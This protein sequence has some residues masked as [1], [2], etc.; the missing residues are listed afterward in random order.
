MIKKTSRAWGRPIATLLSLLLLLGVTAFAADEVARARALAFQGPEHRQEA[1]QLLEERLKAM[2]DDGDAL[3]LYGTILSW[4]G[5]YN[6]G[7]AA[8]QKVLDRNPDHSDALPAM[9]NLELW[10]DHP[11][12]AEE[13]ARGALQRHP[14]NVQMLLFLARAQRNENHAHDA[15]ATLDTLLQVE[16]SNEEALQMRRRMIY[17]AKQ[18]EASYSFNSDFFS[19][20]FGAQQEQVLE[21]RGPTKIGSFIAQV[22]RADRFDEHSNEAGVE[23]FPHIRRG[24]YADL[25]F[26]GS[27]DSVLYPQM[28]VGGELYQSVGHGFEAAAGY[29]RLQFGDD[30]NIFTGAIYKYKGNWLYSARLYLTPSDVD[31]S[32]TGAFAARRLFGEEG[33]HD[34]L[35]FRFSYGAS[36]ALATS[37][38][39][40]ISL[41]SSRYSVEYDKGFL[42]NW[43]GDVKLGAGSEDE[44]F[45]EKINHYTAS[46][47]LYY[48]F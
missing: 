25:T 13:L 14:G 44:V 28:Y 31:V 47:T 29:H 15:A 39:D 18:W 11:Q 12:V 48:R 17:A 24:T 41:T 22:S 27:P 38:L 36:K 5:R 23:W 40:L 10:S 3:T 37:T 2:P 1:L 30:I 21:L 7:R 26:G 20:V 46:G 35:E 45:R 8:L 16:P 32:K 43:H 42:K 6:E 34:F 4:E 9:I 33:V 19:S